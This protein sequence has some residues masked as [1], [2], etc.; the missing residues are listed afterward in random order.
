MREIKFRAWSG[1]V[2]NEDPKMMYW[3]P[4]YGGKRPDDRFSLDNWASGN[5]VMQFT[6]L[7]DK[8]GKEIY[9][10]DIM[11]GVINEG[12]RLRIGYKEHE[13]L[14]GE[15]KWDYSGFMWELHEEDKRYIQDLVLVD[16]QE[17]I[18]NIYENPELL[19]N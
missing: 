10:G 5:G 9:E 19:K 4:V 8:N 16:D 18:G 14:I 15:I 2:S 6:G 12:Y 3:Y 1:L 7:L 11:K 13:Y 17:V